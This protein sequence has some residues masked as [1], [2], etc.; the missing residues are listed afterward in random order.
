[1]SEGTD[2]V[3]GEQNGGGKWYEEKKNYAMLE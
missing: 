1:M 3:K 2:S